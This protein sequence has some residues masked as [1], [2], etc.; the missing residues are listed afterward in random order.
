MWEKHKNRKSQHRPP[1]P[2]QT[3]SCYRCLGQDVSNS[4]YLFRLNFNF[5]IAQLCLIFISL[6][7]IDHASLVLDPATEARDEKVDSPVTVEADPLWQRRLE[8]MPA[9]MMISISSALQKI[10]KNSH[11]D[12]P[13]LAISGNLG[14]I[15]SLKYSIAMVDKSKSS[16]VSWKYVLFYFKVFGKKKFD[17]C[18]PWKDAVAVVGGRGY[19]IFCELHQESR[20]Y[21]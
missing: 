5:C 9:D 3:R 4:S 12:L 19:L 17:T 7:T 11:H 20:K 10:C 14:S 16:S 18:L 13:R 6:D 15:W 21:I 1:H 8:V 2:R